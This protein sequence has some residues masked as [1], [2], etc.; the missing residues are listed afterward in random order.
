MPNN[1]LP[2]R[3]PF[4]GP[5]SAF[6]GEADT[7]VLEAFGAALREWADLAAAAESS[8]WRGV[9]PSAIG[10]TTPLSMQAEV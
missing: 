8:R 1:E 5:P 6:M 3:D 9:E 10:R 4:I 7:D 2:Q